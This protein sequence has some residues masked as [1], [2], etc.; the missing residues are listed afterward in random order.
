MHMH[1][2]TAAAILYLTATAPASPAQ[3][4][5]PLSI[6]DALATRTFGIYAPISLSADGRWVAYTIVD[7]RKRRS[8][9]ENA[10]NFLSTGAP[11]F[12]EGA[13]LWIAD[14]KTGAT[15]DLTGHA[16]NSWDGVWSPDGSQ[17]AFYS[18]RDGLAR[19]WV[20]DRATATVR[21]VSSVIL[22]AWVMFE[23]P[24]WT[25]DGAALMVK[26]LPEGDTIGQTEDSVGKAALALPNDSTP[27]AEV[28]TANIGSS[29]TAR[30]DGSNPA[31]I[32]D[33]SLVRISDGTVRRLVRRSQ[34]MQYW[35]SPTGERVAYTILSSMVVTP[36][37]TFV[38]DI[39]ITDLKTGATRIIARRV[40]NFWGPAISWSPDGLH[41]AFTTKPHSYSLQDLPDR[42]LPP[43]DCYVASVLNDSV[44][45]LTPGAHVDLG[46]SFHAPV[47]SANGSTLF[48]VGGGELWRVDAQRGGL[49]PVGRV[50]GRAAVA[51][52]TTGPFARPWP[53]NAGD[54]LLVRT[55]DEHTL[56]VGVARIDVRT[57]VSEL[58]YEDD[59]WL[60]TAS[61]TAFATS[62]AADVFVYQRESAAHPGD[63][64]VAE[65]KFL[66]RRR[67]TH[68]NPQLDDYVFGDRRLI[69]WRSDDGDSLR[70]ALLLP[71]GYKT[72]K[73]YPLI[74][75]QYGGENW[76]MFANDF[77][78]IPIVGDYVQILATR[79]YAVLVP[80]A[81]Q[82]I[83]T[84]MLDLAKTVL[85]GVNRAIELGVADPA[86]LG[87]MGLSYGCFSTLMIIVQTT[88]FKAAECSS[89]ASSIIGMAGTEDGWA[90]ADSGQGKMGATI[91]QRR[92]RYIENSPYF[93][94]D[95]VT[96]PI[97]MVNGTADRGVPSFLADATYEA[98]RQLGKRVEYV[99]YVGESHAPMLYSR[100][101]VTDYLNRLVRWF[102]T[103]LSD[104]SSHAASDPVR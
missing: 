64:W 20:W 33:L 102:G 97:L 74:S 8:H 43:G 40:P 99:R 63:L 72:G 85:P 55:L 96:T 73:R 68:I 62:A 45:D 61:G 86:R 24:E 11:R 59:E 90:W 41:I 49:E 5:K 76:S 79:G 80:D 52:I 4:V 51:I 2:M 3:Q 71:A 32:A 84:P 22:R 1:R 88:R 21:R 15:R 14:T 23:S 27:T 12:A 46:S 47:W 44:R 18:D 66:A 19:L 89:G 50:P 93:Y 92:D 6:E 56:N 35:I 26:A 69:Y 28:R 91:W 83:G 9:S 81:P 87:I 34:I 103:Y 98:L 67:L 104:S 29:D 70:G 60:P 65:P 78:V 94:L 17:L 53:S 58:A 10:P 39:G 100:A 57:G 13:E 75:Y 54:T 38:Y 101:N 95:R 31:L 36:E 37:V 82:H 16:G 42:R 77:G 7:P 48:L 30:V 25:P